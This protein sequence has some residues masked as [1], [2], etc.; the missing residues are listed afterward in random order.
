MSMSDPI[1]APIITPATQEDA[2]AISAILSGWIDETHWMPRVHSPDEEQGF[3]ALLVAQCHTL[4]A[5]QAGR[6]RGFLAREGEAVHALYLHRDARGQGL[7]SALLARA[8]AESAR[9]VL[10]TFQANPGAQRFYLRHGFTEAERSDG[11]GNDENLPDIRY[12]WEGRS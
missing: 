6:V 2:P 9:L 7:G 4:V 10:W 8:K 11:A 5:R 3:G 1:I 12:V